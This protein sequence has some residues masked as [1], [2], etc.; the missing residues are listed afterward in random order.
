LIQFRGSISVFETVVQRKN[1]AVLMYSIRKLNRK[2][3]IMNPCCS[4]VNNLL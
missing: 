3:D 1:D 2:P 4:L